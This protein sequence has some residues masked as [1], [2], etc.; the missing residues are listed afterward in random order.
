MLLNMPD[1][2]FEIIKEAILRVARNSRDKFILEKDKNKIKNFLAHHLPEII[3]EIFR[4]GEEKLKLLIIFDKRKKRIY[5]F[6]M[7]DVIEFLIKNA[8]NN[9][10]FSEKGIIYIGDFIRIQ[11]KGGNGKHIK[12][13]KTNWNH[14]GNQLQF[15][16]SPLKFAEYIE[17][18]R[19]IDFCT[20]NQ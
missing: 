1:E 20:I 12:I 4:R 14:P 9:I 2:V 3:N 11:R 6:R 17:S 13:S 15:K 16:F 8:S 19:A 5:M 7:N 18:T 10:S